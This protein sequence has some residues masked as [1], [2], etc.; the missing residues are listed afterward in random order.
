M[1]SSVSVN[2][3]CCDAASDKLLCPIDT[4]I[5]MQ[6]IIVVNTFCDKN[7]QEMSLNVN[8]MLKTR[9]V[10]IPSCAEGMHCTSRSRPGRYDSGTPLY[11]MPASNL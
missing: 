2:Q 4:Y 11:R 6:C 7:F 5:V 1:K 10:Q 9:A 8:P 3:V